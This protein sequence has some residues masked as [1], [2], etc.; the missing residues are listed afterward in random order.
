MT[1]TY[2]T[3]DQKLVGSPYPR[4]TAQECYVIEDILRDKHYYVSCVSRLGCDRHWHDAWL[5]M[6]ADVPRLVEEL[7]KR[8]IAVEVQAEG[9]GKATIIFV[10]DYA[11]E[12]ITSAV[13]RFWKNNNEETMI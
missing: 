7:F 10:Y 9:K 8:R 12:T 3:E 2:F 5:V 6:R 11:A 4:W 1:E 13:R